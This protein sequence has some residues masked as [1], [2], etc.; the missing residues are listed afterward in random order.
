M[1]VFSF[2]KTK[3]LKS[4]K[5]LIF[6]AKEDKVIA[7]SAFLGDEKKFFES[8]GFCKKYNIKFL[9]PASL[10]PYTEPS[11]SCLKVRIYGYPGSG[12]GFVVKFVQFL[13]EKNSQ[14]KSEYESFQSSIGID[15][16]RKM[17]KSIENAQK[18]NGGCCPNFTNFGGYLSTY[19]QHG[20]LDPDFFQIIGPPPLANLLFYLFIS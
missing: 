2:V 16:L 18:G 5:N 6:C 10:L 15:Y 9:H 14:K 11:G 12:N 3:N 7:I 8:M 1:S 4:K 17:W 20:A 13:M 19:C